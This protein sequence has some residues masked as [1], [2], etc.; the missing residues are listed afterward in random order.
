VIPAEEHEQD[1]SPAE[2]FADGVALGRM[3]WV[4][5]FFL[6]G[7]AAGQWLGAAEWWARQW[8]RQISR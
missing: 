4:S 5:P 8:R 1:A 2:D 7:Y 3:Q 6:A